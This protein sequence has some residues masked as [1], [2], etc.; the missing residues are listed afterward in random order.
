[1]QFSGTIS[2]SYAAILGT[3]VIYPALVALA[4]AEKGQPMTNEFM[5]T[6]VACCGNHC[7]GESM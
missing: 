1:M 4:P 5:R 3:L 2:P 7:G 6:A